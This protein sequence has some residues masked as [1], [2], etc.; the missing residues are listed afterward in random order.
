MRLSRA[1]TAAKVGIFAVVML[2]AGWFI[3]RFVNKA[4]GPGHGYVVYALMN[5][6]AGIAK[7][8]QVRMAGIPVGSID[9]VR[10]EGNKARIDV[11]MNPEVALYEDASV[12]KVAS[13]LLG[14][15]YLA[16]GPG[17]EGKRKLKDGDRIL[18]VIE[19]TST[20]QLVREL[21]DIARDVKQVTSSLAQSI[22]TDQGRDDMK[23]IL[24]NLAQATDALNQTVRE[25]RE[26]IR[27]ILVNVEGI[28]RRGAP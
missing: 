26:N 6:A 20:D 12:T 19:A 25:N 23:A 27:N 16:L 14:E 18:L 13:S 9:G 22:G 2:G 10:L 17:T 8:S 3:Y 28:T 4:S 7:H 5:D 11:R 21:A 24:G 1:T 15:Y